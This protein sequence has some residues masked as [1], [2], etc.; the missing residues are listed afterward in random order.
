MFRLPALCCKASMSPGF[1]LH[2]LRAFIYLRVD[3]YAISRAWS[4]KNIYHIKHNSQLLSCEYFLRPHTF[5]T[6]NTF[7][8]HTKVKNIFSL[9][10]QYLE[11][12]SSTG[13]IT[14]AFTLIYGRAG[15]EIKILYY[16]ALYSTY[17]KVTK[18]Q[19]LVEDR[20]TPDMWIHLRD[21]MCEGMSTSLKVCNVKVL[22]EGS[23]HILLFPQCSLC[24]CD[25]LSWALFSQI[26]MWLISLP[27]SYI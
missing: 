6:N 7:K 3:W 5:H 2:L 18:A 23:Y 9:T 14:A 4:P 24:T 13:Y 16:R 19:P 27:S 22:M 11:N 21:W 26:F 20:G 17:R 10:I 12:C 1:S 15:L 25:F 8:K